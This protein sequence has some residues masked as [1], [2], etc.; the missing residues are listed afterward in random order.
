ME[1]R[2]TRTFAEHIVVR[3]LSRNAYKLTEITEKIL[4]L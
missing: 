4:T 1:G 3:I 2:V